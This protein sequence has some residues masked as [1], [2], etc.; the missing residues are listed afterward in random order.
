MPKPTKRIPQQIEPRAAE[1]SYT[2]QLRRITRDM[3]SAVRPFLKEEWPRLRQ[4]ALRE[5]G[6][7]GEGN[8]VRARLKALQAQAQV[9]AEQRTQRAA[10]G[11][12]GV[13]SSHSKREVTRQVK[14]AAG[15][16]PLFDEGELRPLI[17]SFVT[18][19]VELVSSV[20]EQFHGELR[21][22]LTRAISQGTPSRQL[23]KEIAKRFKVADRRA[24]VIAR[25]QTATLYGQ[26]NAAR[27]RQA[28]IKAF[29]WRTSQDERVR[30]VHR[31]LN[32]KRFLYSNPP[33][34]GLPG[35]PIQCRCIAEPDLS[36]R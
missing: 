8:T 21:K 15:T 27:Q 29:I 9:I 1:R 20:G 14:F 30:S 36:S 19:N 35:Q 28:G 12:A 3:T 11:Q 31:S 33:A 4:Q 13:L 6:D 24:R 25:D 18:E 22:I 2:A 10:S 23:S 17:E 5:R 32:G 26:M 7:V 16:E 34:E